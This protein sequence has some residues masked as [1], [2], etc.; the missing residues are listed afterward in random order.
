VIWR[1]PPLTRMIVLTLSTPNLI[2]Q[3]SPD[4]DPL[5][6][7]GAITPNEC[8]QAKVEGDK[9]TRVYFDSSA[10]QAAYEP[11]FKD[12]NK[13]YQ[14]A[15]FKAGFLLHKPVTVRPLIRLSSATSLYPELAADKVTHNPHDPKNQPCFQTA[16]PRDPVPPFPLCMRTF[17][18]PKQ[19]VSLIRPAT[20]RRG[21]MSEWSADL[22]GCAQTLRNRRDVVVRHPRGTLTHPPSC[23][24][25]AVQEKRIGAAAAAAAAAADVTR[26]Q[27]AY[28]RAAA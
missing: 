10:S 17:T 2:S 13:A 15:G 8:P 3:R 27:A 25:I 14:E 24:V 20:R 19:R 26:W 9:P 5:G 22:D 11:A 4:T 21:R 28:R 6:R 16:S 12:V 7:N 23:P 18:R 1:V